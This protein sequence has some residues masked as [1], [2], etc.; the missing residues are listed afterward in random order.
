MADEKEP[1]WK[2]FLGITGGDLLAAGL[3]TIFGGL[4]GAKLAKTGEKKLDL[5]DIP[6]KVREVLEGYWKDRVDVMMD[7][8]RSKTNLIRDLITEAN[9]KGFIKAR[10]KHHKKPKQYREWWIIA[11]LASVRPGN[12]IWYM[13]HLNRLLQDPDQ[14]AGRANFFAELEGLNSDELPQWFR[15]VQDIGEEVL[16]KIW[17]KLVYVYESADNFSHDKITPHLKRATNL[18]DTK[19]GKSL[20]RILKQKP[21]EISS[22]LGLKK[23][24][25]ATR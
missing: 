19:V 18:L 13:K 11:R 12:R 24:R 5:K 22:L 6:D 2:T 20:D 3:A 16:G 23:I 1:L 8:A 4:L 15:Q 10:F 9:L 17:K 7:I 25:R 14:N 21:W